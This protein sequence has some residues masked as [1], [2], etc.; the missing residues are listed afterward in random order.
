[1]ALNIP[2]WIDA[3]NRPPAVALE[4]LADRTSSAAQRLDACAVLI[5]SGVV[6]WTLPHV[7]ALLAS[8]DVAA[9]A[10]QL[11]D[12]CHALAEFDL[13]DGG[14]TPDNAELGMSTGNYWLVPAGSRKTLIA[15]T[16]WAKRLS[17]SVYMMQRILE[18]FGVNVIYLFDRD[19]A[20]YLGGI[21]DPWKGIEATADLLVRL[22]RGL[23]TETVYCMGQ[24]TGGYGALRYGLEL[25]ARATLAFSPL[26]WQI[27]RPRPQQRIQAAVGRVLDDSQTNL[28]S[29]YLSRQ[30]TPS[31]IVVCGEHNKADMQS[32]RELSGLSGVETLVLNG[33]SDHAVIKH[34]LTTKSL[35]PLM[36][37]FLSL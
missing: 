13:S 20:F 5:Q 37:R 15:F 32:A 9:A 24:S 10:R 16:G 31:T 29:L 6:N 17:V 22:C 2:A 36:T 21:G 34:L 14:H 35:G 28:R 1:M 30:R 26:I 23:G 19:N 33:V 4:T 12:L 7:E 8:R 18:P 11:R 25:G 3:L 27:G